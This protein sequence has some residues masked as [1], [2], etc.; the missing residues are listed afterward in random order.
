[1]R[2]RKV[3]ELVIGLLYALGAGFQGF[4]TL[5]HSERFYA[6]MADQAWLRPAELFIVKLL[7]PNSFAITVFVVVFQATLAIAIFSRGAA[8]RPALMAGGIFSIIGAL[9]GGPVET[10]GYALLAVLHFRLA[11][12]RRAEESVPA[13]DPTG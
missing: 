9:T 7:V 4:D 1:M 13:I 10:I 2:S 12:A 3:A 5:R 8:V 11:S 6:D